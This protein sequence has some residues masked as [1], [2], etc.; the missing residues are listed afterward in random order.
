MAGE[1]EKSYAGRW[2]ARLRGRV[3]AQGGTPEQARRAAQSRYKE[4]PEIIFMPT[5][6][7]LT[8]PPILDSVRAALPD[9]LTVYLAGGAVRDALLGRH[10]HDLDFVLERD[11]I[12]IGRRVANTL[13]RTGTG[14]IT[15]ADFYP[16]DPER[17]TGRVILTNEDGTRIMMDFAAFRGPDLEADILGRDFTLNAIALNLSDNTIHDPLGGA[18]DLKEKRLRACSPSTFKDDPVRILRGVRLAANFGFHILLET[19]KAMKEAVD[20][21]GNISPE[22]TRDELFRLLDGAQPAACLRALDLLGALDKVLPEL[23]ALKGVEQTA[24]HTHDVWEHTLATMS[25]LESV[26]AALAPDYNPDK[27]SDLLNGLLVLRIGRYRQ[28]I[29]ETFAA[30]LTADR[31]LRSL[32]FLAALYHDVAKPQTKKA[33]EEVQLR[34]WD[35][36]QQGAEIAASR[37]RALAMSN[38]EATRLETV[39]RNHMRILFHTN[40]LVR[41][42]KPPSRRAVYRF[43]RD[44]GAAGVDVCLLTLADLR[45]TYEQTLPQETWAAALDVVRLML[46]NWFE[47]P[48]E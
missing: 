8:F 10:I 44:T 19:R 16:L 7:P 48:A 17:D 22:R 29:S 32:L 5:N 35:H 6:F 11:A 40:R 47:K 31:S 36:D 21:L 45:A 2:V 24:P 1:D 30:P 28:Q 14:T 18:M 42:G 12:K 37:G 13:S 15:K 25:H 38:D 39:I 34:F 20:L 27:A 33:D 26:L 9:G 3:I 43:F 41:E 4:T 23:S 46:E